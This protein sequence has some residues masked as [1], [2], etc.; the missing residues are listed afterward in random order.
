MNESV[1]TEAYWIARAE[2]T[3]AQSGDRI[4]VMLT[5]RADHPVDPQFG[6]F[7]WAR[8][9]YAVEFRFSSREEAVAVARSRPGPDHLRPEPSQITLVHITRRTIVTTRE[10]S[11]LTAEEIGRL[12]LQGA[13]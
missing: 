8:Q 6:H 12:N 4:T 7:L 9:D 10:E 5:F 1:T 2:M 3:D 13:R 11:P